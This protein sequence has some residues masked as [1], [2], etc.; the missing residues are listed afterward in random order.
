[1]SSSIESALSVA[2]AFYVPGARKL[3]GEQ[4]ETFYKDCYYYEA[5]ETPTWLF[6]T[7]KH[8]PLASRRN[9]KLLGLWPGCGVLVTPSGIAYA[10][11]GGGNIYIYF[12]PGSLS[13]KW[14][15]VMMQK[16]K[17]CAIEVS[18]PLK[19]K[20]EPAFVVLPKSNQR[21]S[22]LVKPGRPLSSTSKSK[23][24]QQSTQA[25]PLIWLQHGGF[26]GQG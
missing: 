22:L 12:L 6:S 24:H 20:H 8:F 14:S 1:M 21:G 10:V 2:L 4:V 9:H 11:K 18:L 3:A 15:I 5:G 16:T 23:P 7:L 25:T 17:R 13:R 19:G 26:Y